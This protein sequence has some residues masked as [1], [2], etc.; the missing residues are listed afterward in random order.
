MDTLLRR[1]STIIKVSIEGFDRLVF[2][3]TLKPIA[4]ALEMQGFLK[5]QVQQVSL[6]AWNVQIFLYP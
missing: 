4:F 3:G 6:F 2:K 5:S 1:F